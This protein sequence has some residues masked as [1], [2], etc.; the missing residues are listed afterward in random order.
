MNKR[1]IIIVIL[2]A[3]ALGFLGGIIGGALTGD[4]HIYIDSFTGPG[5]MAGDRAPDTGPEM[6]PASPK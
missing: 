6:V 3:G 1:D 5:H 2:V 4:I